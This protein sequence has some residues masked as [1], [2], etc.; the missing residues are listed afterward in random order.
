V[1]A[2]AEIK[3]AKKQIATAWSGTLEFPPLRAPLRRRTSF[4]PFSPPL[5]GEEEIQ[6]VVDTLRS[7]WI[8]TG[9]KTRQFAIDFAEYLGAIEALPL[10][11]CTAALHTALV[12]S[13][14][15][16][17]D[18]VITTPMTFAASV[19]VIEHVGATPV[20]VD[21]EPDTLNIDPEL[22]ERAVTPRTRA[23][24]AVHY[25]GHP[26][27][28]DSLRKIAWK[29]DLVLVEDAA[30]ALPAKYKGV[31]IGA[32][33]N[34]TAF[35]FYATKN[36][37]T[38][39]G[40][41]LTGDGD[42]IAKARIVSLHGMSCDAWKRYSKGGSWR[43]EVLSPGFKYN[44]TDIAAALGLCQLRKLNGFQQ[45]RREIVR[46][47][48]EAFS[49]CDALEVPVERSD[50]EH[51]WHLY[52]LRLNADCLEIDRDR[53]IEELAERNIATSVHFIP[54]HLHPYYRDK[55]ELLPKAFPVAYENFT[56]MLTLPLNPSM[57]DEDVSDVIDAVLDVVTVFRR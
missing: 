52:V 49:Y 22:V 11:S 47:Y 46:A 16:T 34:P 53:F 9:P 55:Y 25:A 28:L 20:L 42:F 51:A 13:E 54:I 17:G 30:H 37:T 21:V 5:I 7:E 19:N 41:M 23:I 18:E 24:I 36:L 39:E 4:L 43:Y 33:P 10:N 2:P 48:M 31:N 27:E 14:I 1:T 26:A 44:M 8:T 3:P 6:A 38:G 57:S 32:G 56:R 12:T 40:G 29:H 45:R 35:S 50:V 15:S